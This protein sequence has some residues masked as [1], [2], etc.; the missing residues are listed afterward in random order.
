MSFWGDAFGAVGG[1]FNSALGWYGQKESNRIN[2]HIA[3]DTREWQTQMDNTKWQRQ[4][5]DMKLAGINPMLAVNQGVGGIPPG[6]QATVQNELGNVGAS[7][8]EA[9]RAA[10]ELRNLNESTQKI[11]SDTKLNLQ[12]ANSAKAT[13]AGII[14]D[15]ERKKLYGKIYDDANSAYDILKNVGQNISKQ[16]RLPTVSDMG[17]PTSEKDAD[18]FIKKHKWW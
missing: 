6:S 7:A 10:A 3:S 11:R 1:L 14:A 17:L 15:N 16:K 18:A 5:E 12:L 2:K 13:E 9:S 4:V 8:I